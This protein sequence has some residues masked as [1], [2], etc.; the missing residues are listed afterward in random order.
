LIRIKFN[1]ADKCGG[2]RVAVFPAIFACLP[3]AFGVFAKIVS[4]VTTMQ[5]L[6]RIVAAASI[7]LCV[8][9]GLLL[10]QDSQN[11]GT[12][13][14]SAPAATTAAPAAPAAPP[15][16]P[17]AAPAASTTAPSAATAAT[18][19]ASPAAAP[20]APTAAPAPSPAGPPAAKSA[21]PKEEP[22][23]KTSKKKSVKLTRQQEI[24]K[25]IDSGTVPKRYRRSVPKEYQPYI[26][27]SK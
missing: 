27:F 7:L 16:T 8:P 23:T 19:A 13:V 11:T 25:S 21:A 18:P 26:P 4:G 2:G 6:S 20:A 10:A 1:S 15:A 9:T 12:D 14:P 22:A 5:T 17:P 3:S 24:D